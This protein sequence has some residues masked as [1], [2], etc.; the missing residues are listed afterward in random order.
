M[1]QHQASALQPGV[2]LGDRG[3]LALVTSSALHLPGYLDLKALAVYS[4]CS[5]RWLRD[6][7]ADPLAPLPHHRI[8]GKILIRRE[9][10]DVW[11]N[12]FRTVRPSTELG[13]LVDDVLD[14]LF[15]K[16]PS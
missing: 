6:R 10:F 11:I 16:Q 12:Q 2:S 1:R 13:T 7:L 9:D 5:V 15:S 14:G 4:S 3:C 8:G